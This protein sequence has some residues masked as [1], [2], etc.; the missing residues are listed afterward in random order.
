MSVPLEASLNVSNHHQPDWIF[1]FLHPLLHLPTL[2]PSS[3]HLKSL[4]LAA[5]AFLPL[6]SPVSTLHHTTMEHRKSIAPALMAPLDESHAPAAFDGRSKFEREQERLIQEI[7]NVSRSVPAP[8]YT[9]R[10]TYLRSYS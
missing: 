10:W 5:D 4:R 3:S 2:F 6:F 1:P 8:L 7:A 9:F